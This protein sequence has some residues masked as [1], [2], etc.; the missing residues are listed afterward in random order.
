MFGYWVTLRKLG[1]GRILVT[2][3]RGRR[4]IRLLG[5]FKETREYWKDRNEG[6]TKKKT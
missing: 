5:D 4:H 2:G 1:T 6:K 3:R